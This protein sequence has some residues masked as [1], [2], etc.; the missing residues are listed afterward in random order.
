MAHCHSLDMGRASHAAG[1]LGKCPAVQYGRWAHPCKGGEARCGEESAAGDWDAFSYAGRWKGKKCF[2]LRDVE[3][4]KSDSACEMLERKKVIRLAGVR[5]VL[6]DHAAGPQVLRH[7]GGWVCF[8]MQE[9]GTC[10]GMVGLGRW[11]GRPQVRGWS[12]G[13]SS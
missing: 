13:G 11:S 6:D 3:K 5:R 2:G 8:C 1:T 7:A 4:E 10:F 9:V 12:R